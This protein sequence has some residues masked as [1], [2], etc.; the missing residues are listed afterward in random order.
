MNQKQIEQKHGRHFPNVQQAVN[1]DSTS[2]PL[3]FWKQ[4]PTGY[5]SGNYSLSLVCDR[6]AVAYGGIQLSDWP[7]YDQA[8]AAANTHSQRRTA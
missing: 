8:V 4:Y 1:F 3:L 2:K 5:S 6:W 7:T